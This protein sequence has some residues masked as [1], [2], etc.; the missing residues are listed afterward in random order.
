MIVPVDAATL[1]RLLA[2][3]VLADRPV[4]DIPGGRLAVRCAPDE[5]FAV[6][7]AAREVLS[8]SGRWPVVVSSWGSEEP[9]EGCL[10][11]EDSA[12]RA[13]VASWTSSPWTSYTHWSVDH[14]VDAEHLGFII[15]DAAELTEA[16][17]PALLADGADLFDVEKLRWDRRT[18]AAGSPAQLAADPWLTRRSHLWFTP[19]GQS[20][21]VV[22][23][24]VATCWE[25][26]ARV[27]YFG[28]WGDEHHA[29][30]VAVGR[31]WADAYGAELVASW[32][33]MLQW[34][35]ARPPTTFDAAW[36]LAGQQ[37]AVGAS[38]QCDRSDLAAALLHTDSWFL[39]YRP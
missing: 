31:E 34:V 26:T 11:D 29:A 18:A 8:V 35:A 33:T 19:T 2:S 25:A 23:L 16:D 12:F 30:L 32:G 27:S 17:A 24:P 21:A 14:P 5:V 4:L 36:T 7:S 6:W 13:A 20:C 38:L 10:V 15:R 39:H 28:A 3:T 37:L 9:W 22:L 1:A